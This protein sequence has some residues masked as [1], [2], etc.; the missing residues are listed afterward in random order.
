MTPRERRAAA[1][2]A[3]QAIVDAAKADG[4]RALTAEEQEQFDSL[5][6]E[7]EE[8]DAAIG[9]QERG[10]AGGTGVPATPPQPPA[11]TQPP[12][13]QVAP[14]AAGQRDATEAERARVTDIIALCRDFDVDPTDHIRDGHSLD[15]V[16]SAILEGM[17]QTGAP[18]RVQVTRDE[19]DT[20]RERASD[21][22]VMRAG[23]HVEPPAEGAGELRAMWIYVNTLDKKSRK[24]MLFF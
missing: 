3:Q 7:I 23:L 5:Q 16:R 11:G 4:S 6:R 1:L 8:A 21:A 9:A 17:R 15:E 2:S 14:P 10:L 22:L 18:I 20:F 19:G 24:I 12:V 13:Q